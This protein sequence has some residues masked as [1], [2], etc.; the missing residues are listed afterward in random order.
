[1]SLKAIDDFIDDCFLNGDDICRLDKCKL[2][3]LILNKESMA[4]HLFKQIFDNDEFG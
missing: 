2:K 4:S 1:M 3:P